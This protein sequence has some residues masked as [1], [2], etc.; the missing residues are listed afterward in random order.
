MDRRRQD[1]VLVRL[2]YPEL[3]HGEQLDWVIIPNFP[4]PPGWNRD[5]TRLLFFLPPEYPANPPDNF[6][7]EPGLR[8]SSGASPGSYDEGVEFRGE[9]G[10]TPV[11]A[12]TRVPKVEVVKRMILGIQ[13]HAKVFALPRN[14]RD[15]EALGA[16]K[17][18]DVIFG[19]VDTDSGRL[20]VNELATAY[21]IPYIDCGVGITAQAGR[22]EEIGGRVVLVLPGSFCL[23]CA[24]EID[25]R[26]AS[27]ELASSEEFAFRKARGYVAGERVEAP[28]VV[29]LNG[30]ISSL[31]VD[32]FL[33]L[34]TGYKQ[35]NFCIYYDALNNTLNIRK[36]TRRKDCI[37]CVG[38]AGVGDKANLS[39]YSWH[40]KVAPPS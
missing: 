3:E 13:P 33:A 39:R 1:L 37:H 22:I 36:I 32:A 9:L 14:V 23:L 20:I 30:V 25:L 5:R 11:N 24:Q 2:K 17:D 34:V 40:I 18:V 26:V 4:L 27:D 19:C 10:A 15:R 38:E 8:T 28:S 31:A 35:P 21:L 29:S 7:V 6:Y 16:L 12:E